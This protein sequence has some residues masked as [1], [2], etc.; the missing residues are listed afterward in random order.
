MNG[1]ELLLGNDFGIVHVFH[2]LKVGAAGG[3]CMAF[4][5][6]I[7]R[8]VGEHCIPGLTM[9]VTIGIFISTGTGITTTTCGLLE[10]DGAPLANCR[11][12]KSRALEMAEDVSLPDLDI[13]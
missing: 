9:G 7:V 11:G 4:L 3:E 10:L 12:W 13:V 5:K 2:Q 6:V 8:N 1:L